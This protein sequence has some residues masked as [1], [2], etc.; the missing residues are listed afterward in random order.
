M[1]K[2]LS[3]SLTLSC[4]AF[5]APAPAKT[6]DLKPPVRAVED[7]GSANNLLY[8]KPD[9]AIASGRGL[10]SSADCTDAAGVIY[11]KGSAGFSACQRTRALVKPEE[12]L[13]GNRGDSF[14]LFGK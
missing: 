1:M 4:I 14:L 8:Q 11:R 13:P 7:P 12:S 5:A 3:L 2:I 6:I 9:P 10:A